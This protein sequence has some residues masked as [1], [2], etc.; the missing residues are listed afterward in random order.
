MLR[1]FL[2]AGL[3]LLTCSVQADERQKP[4]L[5]F[6]FKA[7]SWVSSW[8]GD[9]VAEPTPEPSYS[10]PLHFEDGRPVL[11]A[12]A[13]EEDRVMREQLFEALGMA[14]LVP[15]GQFQAGGVSGRWHMSLPDTDSLQLSISA[16]W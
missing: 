12:S 13:A 6:V 9:S 1:L 16:R 5:N 10:Q 3:L 4:D 15:Q 7:K 2:A 8:L 14:S 11:Y